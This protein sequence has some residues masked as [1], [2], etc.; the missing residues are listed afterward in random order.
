MRVGGCP[1][2]VAQW[3]STGGS[4]KPEVSW[5]QLLPAAGLFHFPLFLP[6]NS[7][8]S[9]LKARCSYH[10]AFFDDSTTHWCMV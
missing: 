6:P 8:I 1:A 3:Q 5:V 4:I 10:F 7:F 2:V 9:S